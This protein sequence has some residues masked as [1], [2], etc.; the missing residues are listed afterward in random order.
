MQERGVQQRKKA[1]EAA[2][3]KK[4]EEKRARKAE[5]HKKT[6]L[7]VMQRQKALDELVLSQFTLAP[8]GVSLCTRNCSSN[9]K[10]RPSLRRRRRR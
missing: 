4:R 1:K 3:A 2:K 10:S 8:D 7:E 6:Q 5:L 9:S